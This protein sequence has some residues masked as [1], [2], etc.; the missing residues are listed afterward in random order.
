MVTYKTRRR[1]A[2][3]E[4]SGMSQDEGQDA[5][6]ADALAGARV[7]RLAT[8]G[9]GQPHLV[10]VVFAV[11]DGALWVPV[12]GKPKRHTR[13]KRL[14]NIR[15]NPR[16]CLLIDHYE[17]D[18]RALWW[19]RVDGQASVVER[20]DDGFDDALA[21]LGDKYPQY[22]SV[23]ISSAIRIEIDKVSHWRARGQDPAR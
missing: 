4:Q 6:A 9:A 8:L 20:H 19:V 1:P 5:I 13:L 18:W 11:C 14:E 12:D 2:A 17:E 7:A 10:P 3:I 23:P 21:A 15:A 16:V 22:A